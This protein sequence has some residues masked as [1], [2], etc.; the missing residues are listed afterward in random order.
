MGLEQ[1]CVGVVICLIVFIMEFIV[2]S[3]CSFICDD[4]FGF[5][6][7]LVFVCIGLGICI[8][9]ILYERGVLI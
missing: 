9:Y 5:L 7:S 4:E 8:T 3:V 2:G 6:M 1:F